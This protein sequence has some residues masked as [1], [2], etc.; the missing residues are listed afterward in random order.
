[1]LGN[2]APDTPAPPCAL[3]QDGAKRGAGGQIALLKGFI[4]GQLG[5]CPAW[6]AEPSA[7]GRGCFCPCL[8]D[9]IAAVSLWAAEFSFQP[10]KPSPEPAASAK[11]TVRKHVLRSCSLPCVCSFGV[12]IVSFQSLKAKL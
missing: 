7:R 3:Q 10:D 8:G 5:L 11:E 6:S 9:A 12:E 4:P 1:M 2:V